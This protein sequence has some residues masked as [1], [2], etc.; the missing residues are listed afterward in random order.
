M[1]LLFAEDEVADEVPRIV[2]TN[3]AAHLRADAATSFVRLI[4]Y[5]FRLVLLL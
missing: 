4:Y 3:H 1:L 2:G 5:P